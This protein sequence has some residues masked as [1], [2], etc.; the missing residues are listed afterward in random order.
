MREV[1]KFRGYQDYNQVRT[2]IT[3]INTVIEYDTA[4]NPNYEFPSLKSYDLE[5]YQY[6]VYGSF[7][8]DS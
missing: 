2:N 5:G 8:E 1:R 4:V 3:L 6:Q 7:E